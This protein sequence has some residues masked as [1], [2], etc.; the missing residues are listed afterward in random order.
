[1]SHNASTGSSAGAGLQIAA[2]LSMLQRLPQLEVVDMQGV[3]SPAEGT[4]P[5]WDDRKCEAMSHAATLSKLL[6]KKRP[7]GR[8]L[9][10]LS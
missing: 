3:H 5:Y 4:Q 7:P 2:P 9:L 10:D 1:M 6:K 8:V